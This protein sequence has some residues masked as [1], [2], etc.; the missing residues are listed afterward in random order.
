MKIDDAVVSLVWEGTFI[1]FEEAMNGLEVGDDLHFRSNAVHGG[2]EKTN[3][4]FEI[5]CH[6]NL[7]NQEKVWILV[8][9]NFAWEDSWHN[10]LAVSTDVRAISEYIRSTLPDYQTS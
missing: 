1:P 8:A 10:I 3:T 5:H 7:A 2:E 6:L 4:H 9:E